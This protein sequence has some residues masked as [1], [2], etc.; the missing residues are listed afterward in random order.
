MEARPAD[1][2]LVDEGDLQARA[3]RPGTPRYSRRCPRRARRDRNHW[4]SRRPWVRVPRGCL[5]RGRRG[6]WTAGRSG[7]WVIAVDGTRGVEAPATDGRPGGERG[8]G[9]RLAA[10]GDRPDAGAQSMDPA[11]LQTAGPDPRRLPR[12]IDPDGR[13]RGPAVRRPGSADDRLR[14]DR[15]HQ[16]ASRARPEVG[17]VR[18][19]RR[20][21]QGRRAGPAGPLRD[22]RRPARRGP[23]RRGRGGRRHLVG[24]RRVPQRPRGGTGSGRCS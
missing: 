16:R 3:G 20:P 10:S 2:V 1:L 22:R 14:A 11:I 5:C 9:A 12:R 23:V 21:A 7:G 18:G 8:P 24:L 4:T 15:R 13:P 17:G 19:P 6:T